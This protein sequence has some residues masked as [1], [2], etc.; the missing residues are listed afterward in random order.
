M[1]AQAVGRGQGDVTASGGGRGG[2]NDEHGGS[3][4]G[5]DGSNDGRGG[6]GG[7]L[8]GACLQPS[9]GLGH[10]FTRTKYVL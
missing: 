3:E 6:S 1:A 4:G 7:G 5:R 9:T 2:S 8:G 10:P